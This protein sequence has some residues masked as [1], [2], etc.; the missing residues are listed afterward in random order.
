M[1]VF[2]LECVKDSEVKHWEKYQFFRTILEKNTS[3]LEHFTIQRGSQPE[4]LE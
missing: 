3:S 1:L 2:P 4:M